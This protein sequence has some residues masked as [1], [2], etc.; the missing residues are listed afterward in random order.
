MV[1]NNC[2]A[3]NF[4]W[5]RL[6]LS[7]GKFHLLPANLTVPNKYDVQISEKSA[8]YCKNNAG[9]RV[10]CSVDQELDDLEEET[11]TRPIPTTYSKY[12]VL[13]HGIFKGFCMV[14]N[15]RDPTSRITFFC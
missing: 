8:Y 14:S 1:L 5:I 12:Y 3:Q 7:S 6:P 10:P 11:R 4:R 15:S 13:R 2:E 9:Q